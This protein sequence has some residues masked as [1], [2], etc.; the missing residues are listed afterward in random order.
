MY[1]CP[2]RASNLESVY[3]NY[4]F[5]TGFE[6]TLEKAA[7]QQKHAIGITDPEVLGGLIMMWKINALHRLGHLLPGGGRLAQE[8]LGLGARAGMRGRPLPSRAVRELIGIGYAPQTM[9]AFE[10]AH[11]AGSK[12]GPRLKDM[13]E[14]LSLVHEQGQQ[15]APTLFGTPKTAPTGRADRVKRVFTDPFTDK[16]PD[17]GRVTELLSGVPLESTGARRALDYAF[18]PVSEVGKDLKGLYG[19]ARL[20]HA[21]SQ[22]PTAAGLRQAPAVATRSISPPMPANFHSAVQ[23]LGTNALDALKHRAMA[24]RIQLPETIQHALPNALASRIPQKAITALTSHLPMP[25]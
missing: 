11:A 16:T 3:N 2:F 23:G 25:R 8:L 9:T 14:G 5:K 17:L 22:N 20:M 24:A 21:L 12:F 15:H 13:R 7:A 10:K 18:T 1:L 19:K 6:P 4:M